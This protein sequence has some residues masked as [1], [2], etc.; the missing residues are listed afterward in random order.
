MRPD[1]RQ[2]YEGRLAS[3]PPGEKLAV[4]ASGVL[5]SLILPT[6]PWALFLLVAA[7]MAALV[8]ARLNP[9][10]YLTL[11]LAPLGFIATGALGLSL[12]WLADFPWLGFDGAAFRRA[13]LVSLRS[14]SACLWLLWLALTTPMPKLA[15][16]MRRL[17]VLDLLGDV[18]LLIHRQ[19]L[20]L[21]DTAGAMQTAQAA[22]LGYDGHRRALRSLGMLGANLWPR[23]LARAGGM[24]KGLA[25]RDLESATLCPDKVDPARMRVLAAVAALDL[26]ILLGVLV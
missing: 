19:L 4:A 13:L 18:L 16:L 23:A 8:W 17:P 2:A 20:L 3:L 15:A 14:Y 9:A 6:W 5:L 21:L 10:L 11:A 7:L 26:L 25:A 1:F 22:R 24:Q 12:V